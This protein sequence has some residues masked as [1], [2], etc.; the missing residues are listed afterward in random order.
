MARPPTSRTGRHRAPAPSGGAPSATE[1]VVRR[2]RAV[3]RRKA[4]L[5]LVAL[6]AVVAAGTLVTTHS[7][8]SSVARRSGGSSGSVNG[9][10]TSS[11][12]TGGPTT[13]PRGGPPFTVAQMDLPL[14]DTSRT[15]DIGG[16]VGPRQLPTT[17]WYPTGFRSGGQRPLIVFAPGYRQCPVQYQVLLAAWAADGFVVAAPSFPLTSCT[18]PPAELDEADELNQPTDVAFVINQLLAASATGSPGSGQLR[19]R[20]DPAEVAVAGQSDGGNTVA[21]LGFDTNQPSAPIKAV[22]V[23]SGEQ[24]PS[25]GGT[26]FPPGSPPMLVVQGTADT[27][28][29]PAESVQLYNDDTGGPKAMVLLDGVGHLGAYENTD[30]PAEAVVIQV[31]E[32]FLDLFVLD[33]PSAA[34]ALYQAGQQPGVDSLTASFGP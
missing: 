31:T 14:V 33:Q 5:S 29:P 6:V 34:A 28:N 1:L 12:P 10:A 16:H 2:R 22:M 15:V 18:V 4:L 13:A 26:W 32:D 8:G 9:S 21:A 25:F 20:I 7:H 24:L 23:L 19:G 3:A 30:P 27:I 17:V 11:G